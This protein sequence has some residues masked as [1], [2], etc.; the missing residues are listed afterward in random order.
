[1]EGANFKVKEPNREARNRGLGVGDQSEESGRETPCSEWREPISRLRGKYIP[2]I[3]LKHK[4]GG[5]S[6][7]SRGT[8]D[9]SQ[10]CGPRGKCS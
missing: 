2:D 7:D 1:M 4:K 3:D 10:K 9:D 5:A 8:K 6:Y